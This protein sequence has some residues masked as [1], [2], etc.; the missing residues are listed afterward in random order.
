MIKILGAVLFFVIA[1]CLSLSCSN[2]SKPVDTVNTMWSK[3]LSPSGVPDTLRYGQSVSVQIAV[4]DS[5]GDA[6]TVSLAGLPSTCYNLSMKG[7]TALVNLN[8]VGDSLQYDSLYT[9]HIIGRGGAAVDSLS[10]TY[11]IMVIDT[12]RLGGVRKL[13]TGMW[14]LETGAD[15]TITTRDSSNTSFITRDTAEHHKYSKVIYATPSG[16]EMV[17]VVQ[18]SDTVSTVAGAAESTTTSFLL[19]HHSATGVSYVYPPSG[20]FDDSIRVKAYDLPLAVNKSWQYVNAAGDTTFHAPFGIINVKVK[21]LISIEGTAQIPGV[22][23]YQFSGADRPCFQVANA[24]T[25]STVLTCDTSISILTLTI[26]QGDTIASSITQSQASMYVNT[27][28]S[29]P[30]YSFTV[31]TKVDT[32]YIDGVVSRG[33]TKKGSFITSY[34]DAR[35][36]VTLVK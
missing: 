22:T 13:I 15:T 2:P 29:I 27:E 12:A 7:D 20:W 4:G 26:N 30:L 21:Y 11:T 17:Y 16:S 34:F 31:E 18:T 32:N 10:L 5:D 8:L 9:V 3:V 33:T 19:L 23:P 25:W 6:A 36:N 28:L 14:W 35:K 1:A 24:T